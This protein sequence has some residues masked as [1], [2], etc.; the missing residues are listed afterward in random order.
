MVRENTIPW[1]DD[2]TFWEKQIPFMFGEEKFIAAPGE[3]SAL[4][5][6]LEIEPEHKI[7]DLSCGVGRHTNEFARRGFTVDGVDRT[8][9]YLQRAKNDAQKEKLSV[10]YIESD[11]REYQSPDTYN[12]ILSM[13]TSFGFFEDNTEQKRVLDNIFSSLKSGGLFVMQTLGKEVLARIFTPLHWS[14]NESGVLI[15]KREMIDDWSRGCMTKTLIENV[16]T[17][18]TWEITHYLYSASEFKSL[19]EATGFI[20]IKAY[21]NLDGSPY[22]TEAEMLVVVGTKP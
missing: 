21:G 3:V 19:L 9:V 8:K 6:L 15:V 7:L 5:E 1:Y 12:I 16:G 13:Y 20:D 17:R 2:D 11:M 18:H 4:I 10:N 22:D 14:A